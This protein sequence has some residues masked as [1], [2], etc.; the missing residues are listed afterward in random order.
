MIV[1]SAKMKD[2]G[3][4]TVPVEIRRKYDLHTGSLLVFEDRGEYIAVIPAD[5]LVDRTAGSLA[6]Y[7]RNG[8]LEW[9][10]DELWTTIILERE[11]CLDQQMQEESS[12]EHD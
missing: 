2:K 1:R 9:D 10:R 5:N 4:I 8:P 6:E 3:Q 11:N 7:A 12:D